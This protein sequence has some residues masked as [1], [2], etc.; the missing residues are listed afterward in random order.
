MARAIWLVALLADGCNPTTGANPPAYLAIS[1]GGSLACALMTDHSARCWGANDHGQLGNGS[2]ANSSSAVTIAG[3]YLFS[4]VAVGDS[5]ACGLTTGGTVFCWGD[6]GHGELGDSSTTSSPVP[7]AVSGGL[8]FLTM[9]V[10][11]RFACGIAANHEAYCWG[12]NGSGQLGNGLVGDTHTPTLVTNL[13][14]FQRIDAGFSS[15]CAITTTGLAYCWGSDDIGELGIGSSPVGFGYPVRL[16]G[17]VTLVSGAIGNHAACGVTTTNALYCWG[18]NSSGQLG[19]GLTTGPQQCTQFGT[20]PPR[21]CSM[22]P[23]RVA[24]TL[25]F[26]AV[27][28]GDLFACGLTP[29]KAPY[30]WG[31]GS[32]GKLGN[33]TTTGSQ[34]PVA[35]AGA[36]SFTM[37][38]AGTHGAC[39]VETGGVAYCWGAAPGATGML[40]ATRVE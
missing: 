18:D 38:S 10:G 39:G 22:T 9:T 17:N 21:S 2:T 1:V 5:S 36:L 34:F 4:E 27:T 24:D 12:Y 25:Q 11:H 26:T 20:A 29:T 19:A 23:L 35:V 32:H 6:N 37:I 33:G 30:C 3:S 28:V 14:T 8:R 40:V 15:V 16:S 7:V 31:D 13:L